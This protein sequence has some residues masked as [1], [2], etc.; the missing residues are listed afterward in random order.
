MEKSVLFLRID[1]RLIHGQVI[2]GWL[3]VV[4][5]EVL[6]VV[7]KKISDDFMRQEMMSLSMPVE[8]ELEFVS[9]DDISSENV[10]E[11]TFILVTSPED[12]WK[13]LEKGIKPETFNVGGMH[14]RDNKEELFEALHVDHSDRKHFNLILETGTS[15]IFQPT[16]QNEPVLLSDIL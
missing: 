15:P 10:K 11:K 8:I 13:C 9:P 3:P 14:S 5:P 4:R 16:P 12:A 1:D 7:N 6:L 2:V